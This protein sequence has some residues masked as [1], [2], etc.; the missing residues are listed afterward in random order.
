MKKFIIKLFADENDINEKSFVGF[1]SFVI[2][3]IFAI[4]DIVT[5]TLGKE[6]LVTDFIFNSFLIIT[7]GSFGIAS[8]DKWIVK[9][10]SKGSDEEE[11]QEI[12]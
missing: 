2:M 9:K 5:G 10:H 12:Q 11:N 1:C 8:V 6:L 7:L 4:V 3:V